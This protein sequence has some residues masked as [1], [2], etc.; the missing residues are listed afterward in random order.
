MREIQSKQNETYKTWLKIVKKA[1]APYFFLEGE[2]L[3]EDV[4]FRQNISLDKAIFLC[5]RKYQTIL[6]NWKKKWFMDRQKEYMTKM[7]E[8]VS[9]SSVEFANKNFQFEHMNKKISSI[10]SLEQA[11]TYLLS[12]ELLQHLS[13]TVKNPGLALL[14]EQ[15]LLLDLEKTKR[16]LN[17]SEKILILENIQDPGNLG[18][19]LRTALSMGFK[20]V[21][22]HSSCASIYNP[23]VYRSSMGALFNLT[24][25]KSN[26]WEILLSSLKK[27]ERIKQTSTKNDGLMTQVPAKCLLIGASLKGRNLHSWIE[28]YKEA[29]MEGG[30]ALVLGNE[31]KGLSEQAHSYCDELIKIEMSDQVES[32]NV[33]IAG[34]ICMYVLKNL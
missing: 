17:L 28:E 4:L 16:S 10:E 3:V 30:L 8:E 1:Q 15:D 12:E 11:K 22:L 14:L 18:T 34:G 26:T 23:K 7:R 20:Q 9:V 29:R 24:L 32:L 19:L 31:A 21:V 27:Q 2:R 25:Y 13:S 6:S 33:A 5:T